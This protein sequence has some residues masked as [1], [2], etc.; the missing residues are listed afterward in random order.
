VSL[1]FLKTTIFPLVSTKHVALR[2][3]YNT[4]LTQH[5]HSTPTAT[6][7]TEQTIE[8]SLFNTLD[9]LRCCDTRDM[10]KRWWLAGYGFE[11]LNGKSKWLERIGLSKI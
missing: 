9:L 1:A 11:S 6:K 7:Q 4:E 3:N 10:A 8:K 5:K 2:T